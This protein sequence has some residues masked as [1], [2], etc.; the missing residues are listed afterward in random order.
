MTGSWRKG[1]STQSI[2]YNAFAMAG[3][4]SR[5]HGTCCFQSFELQQCKIPTLSGDDV[6]S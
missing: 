3:H 1:V 5:C 2:T 6:M 4:Q